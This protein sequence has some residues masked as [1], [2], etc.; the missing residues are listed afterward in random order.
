MG[1]KKRKRFGGS[2]SS[3]NFAP[4][5]SA[6][7]ESKGMKLESK[8]VQC[9]LFFIH[10]CFISALMLWALLLTLF[11]PSH[12]ICFI[13][14]M[15]NSSCSCSFAVSRFFLSLLLVQNPGCGHGWIVLFTHIIIVDFPI[16]YSFLYH[17]ICYCC[18]LVQQ[19]ILYKKPRSYSRHLL[20]NH[21]Q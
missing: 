7:I 13:R 18:L 8:S 2:G 21:Y 3:S 6:F 9:C 16:F 5:A 11:S 10:F 14:F 17:K 19:G 20:A 4:N 15:L 1:N 12:L